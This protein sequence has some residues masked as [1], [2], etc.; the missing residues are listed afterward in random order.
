MVAMTINKLHNHPELILRQDALLCSINERLSG[1]P[2][3]DFEPLTLDFM[4]DTIDLHLQEA[5]LLEEKDEEQEKRPP[6]EWDE[7]EVNWQEMK[8]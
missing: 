8:L 3:R 2:G 4:L 7:S 5:K 1:K 6:R